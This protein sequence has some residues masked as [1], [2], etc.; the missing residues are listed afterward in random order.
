MTTTMFETNEK[1]NFIFDDDNNY[2]HIYN[3]EQDK[4]HKIMI[5]PNEVVNLLK[6]GIEYKYLSNYGLYRLANFKSKIFLDSF[7]NN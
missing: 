3:D 6:K 7:N 5:K 4:L 2:Y 1:V